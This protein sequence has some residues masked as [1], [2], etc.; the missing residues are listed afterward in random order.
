MTTWNCQILRFWGH[1][2]LTSLNLVFFTSKPQLPLNRKNMPMHFVCHQ[3][4]PTWNNHKTLHVLPQTSTLKSHIKLYCNSYCSLFNSVWSINSK[5][6]NSPEQLYF[7]GWIVSYFVNEMNVY[8]VTFS[9]QCTVT[10]TLHQHCM[11]GIT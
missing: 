7:N 11:P 5:Y 1:V 4:E 6:S 2:G 10:L 8:T 3:L 9:F